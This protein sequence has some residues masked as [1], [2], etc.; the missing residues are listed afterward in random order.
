MDAGA[1]SHPALFYRDEST[2]LAGTVPFVLD[3]LAAGEPVAVAV[4]ERN[5]ARIENALGDAAGE[6]LL[7]DMGDAGRNPGR[8]IPGVLR[9]FADAHPGP[10]RIIGEPIWAGRSEDE[11]PACAQHEALINAAF[12]GRKAT[13]L[14]PYDT[15]SLAASVLADAEATHPLLIDDTGETLSERYAPDDIVAAYNAPLTPAPAAVT[16]AFTLGEL[17]KA[18]HFAFDFATD[19][20]LPGD[21]VQDLVLAVGELTGNSVQHGGGGG[22][23]RL[24]T[25]GGHLVCEV[26]DAGHLADLLAGR[27]PV[28]LNQVGGRGLLLVNHI[29]D[30]VRT[31]RTARGTITRVHLRL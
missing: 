9:A 17:S 14:C 4:P 23:L 10:V 25:D 16:M 20:G 27:R 19:A 6:I 26:E 12:A 8:I 29:A 31:Y 15:T 7:I 3:G 22:E 18:R 28:P 5:L 1:F 2:Y 13:I 21:R 30:L 24:W 11:Y